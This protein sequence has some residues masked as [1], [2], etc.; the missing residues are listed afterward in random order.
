MNVMRETSME[1]RY[2]DSPREVVRLAVIVYAHV[3]NELNKI[4]VG[5]NNLTPGIS[6]R[7]LRA[8]LSCQAGNILRQVVESAKDIGKKIDLIGTELYKVSLYTRF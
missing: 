5:G 6:D 3:T 7:L 2:I 4:G 1:I 8:P